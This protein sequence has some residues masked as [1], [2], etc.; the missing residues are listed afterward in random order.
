M[1]CE[2][3]LSASESGFYDVA[4]EL[5]DSKVEE[6]VFQ[7]SSGGFLEEALERSFRDD[8]AE[9]F[10]AWPGD[11]FADGIIGRAM[12]P[13]CDLIDF[14]LGEACEGRLFSWFSHKFLRE[15]G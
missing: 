12:K 4:A 3:S 9:A 7:H 6:V 10:R 14:I 11:A 1:T 13:S 8:Y 15:R 5:F 2:K